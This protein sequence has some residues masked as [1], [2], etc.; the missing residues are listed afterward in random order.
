VLIKQALAPMP[1][2]LIMALYNVPSST[3]ERAEI[4]RISENQEQSKF[5]T[6]TL[7]ALGKPT[8]TGNLTILHLRLVYGLHHYFKP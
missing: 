6:N 3:C 1:L 2:S 5:A 7:L 8:A 4:I